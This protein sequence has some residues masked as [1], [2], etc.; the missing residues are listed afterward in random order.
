MEEGNLPHYFKNEVV[1]GNS[2]SIH[3]PNARLKMCIEIEIV[4]TTIM[5]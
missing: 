3:A 5:A 2:Q 4:V 1:D